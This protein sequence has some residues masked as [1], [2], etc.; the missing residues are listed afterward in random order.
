MGFLLITVVYEWRLF[1]NQHDFFQ[2]AFL[3]SC[4]Y[5]CIANSLSVLVWELYDSLLFA[6]QT[7]S[8][9]PAF[10]SVDE[11]WEPKVSY[12]NNY[13][14]VTGH[15]YK[16]VMWLQ[17]ICKLPWMLWIFQC[18]WLKEQ[19]CVEEFWMSPITN[20]TALHAP[21]GCRGSIL[22]TAQLFIL[23][24]LPSL[25]YVRFVTFLKHSMI[26]PTAQG[27][28][29]YNITSVQQFKWKWDW[30]K[31]SI[32]LQNTLRRCAYRPLLNLLWRPSSPS[33]AFC[34]R[35]FALRLLLAR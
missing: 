24:S 6:T 35:H 34:Y 9:N 26:V 29:L 20:G 5:F 7:H 22:S 13:I 27:T 30:V 16:H 10:M 33:I 32:F 28:T 15:W 19:C 14:L 8:A 21:F 11:L 23:L 2:V 4:N 17:A 12:Y 3:L 1:T 18:W 25:L 31:W